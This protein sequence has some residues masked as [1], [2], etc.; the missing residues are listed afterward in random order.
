[1][2]AADAAIFLADTGDT[3]SWTPSTG[4]PPITGK[5][6]FDQQT[7][8]IEGGD[9][10]S[11]QYRATLVAADWPGLKRAEQLVISGIT[12]RLRTDMQYEADGLFASVPLTKV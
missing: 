10:L 1:M 7:E 12:Y 8:P 5:V 6:L 2:F 9:G 4:S 11:R 3:A